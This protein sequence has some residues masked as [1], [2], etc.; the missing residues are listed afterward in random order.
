MHTDKTAFLRVF[1][2]F[3]IAPHSADFPSAEPDPASLIG[4]A[5]ML[6]CLQEQRQLKQVVFIWPAG[7]FLSFPLPTKCDLRA[8]GIRLASNSETQST[9]SRELQDVR[10]VAAIAKSG[11]KGILCVCC[12]L[13]LSSVSHLNIGWDPG[14]AHS[15]ELRSDFCPQTNPTWPIFPGASRLRRVDKN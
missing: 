4:V 6:Q 9:V 8:K 3:R 13:V 2:T 5:W 7:V 1:S 12:F 15:S 14:A 11:E 10:A